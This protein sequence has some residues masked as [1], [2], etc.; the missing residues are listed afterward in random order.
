[1]NVAEAPDDAPIDLV[2]PWVTYDER[3]ARDIQKYCAFEG[4][5]AKVPHPAR[6]RE[7]GELKYSLE[8]AAIH[9]PWLNKIY[10]ITNGQKP[11]ASVLSMP[12]VVHCT[13]HDFFRNKE[14]L[15]TFSSSAIGIN[16]AFIPGL[17]E[18]YLLTNDDVFIGRPLSRASILG[19]GRGV[20]LFAHEDLDS[21]HDRRNI[22]RARVDT[23]EKILCSRFGAQNR[24]LFAHTPQLFSKSGM[25]EIWDKYEGEM[26]R[27]SAGRFPSP[28]HVLSRLLFL[29][30]FL[31]SEYGCRDFS[32]IVSLSGQ[33]IRKV[34]RSDHWHVSLTKTGGAWEQRLRQIEEERPNFFCLNDQIAMNQYA[35]VT[36]TV[37]AFL[38]RYYGRAEMRLE[39]PDTAAFSR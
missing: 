11:P 14:H 17:S 35:E 37:R 1:M 13:H 28:D 7:F 30:E 39:V 4:S 38:D 6:Y 27:A 10:V 31:Y 24:K 29:Y 22:W 12:K 2:C 23:T 15:P 3:L 16:A 8:S 33:N 32:E 36:A 25:T 18:Q 19:S 9:M 21:F 5:D 20:H 26:T 34:R